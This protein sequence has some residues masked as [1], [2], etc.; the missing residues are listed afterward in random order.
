MALFKEHLY[1]M[2]AYAPPL[3]GRSVEKHLLLDFN[4]RTLP[5]S[6]EVVE[7][8]CDFI[9]SGQLQ[10]Y[11]SYGDIVSELAEYVGVSPEQLM[12]TNGSDQGIDLVVRAAVS[13]GDRAIIPAPSFAMYRQCAEVEDA[14]ILSPEYDRETGYP[15]CE[16]LAEISV[17]TRLIVVA[18]P[19]NPCGTI[20]SRDDLQMILRAAPDAVVLVD[21]CYYEYSQ[22][23]VV[24]L[25]DKYPNLV[26]ARTFSK[27][28]GLPSLRF[29][30]LVSQANNI[31]QLLKIRGPYDI[32]QLSIVAVRAA[33]AAPD[34]T[35]DYVREV[36]EESKPLLE[37][38][39]DE[40]KI[41]YWPSTANYIWAFFKQPDQLAAY[42]QEQGILVRPKMDPEGKLGLRVTLG[43]L[44]QTRRVI[45]SIEA[46]Y[47]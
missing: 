22:Q 45:E 35:K 44:E 19:N 10:K 17:D 26:V 21:E 13:K 20:V 12:I 28:W 15:T 7:A 34:Y 16:V 27:T 23:T 11:P 37:S 46:F 39:L 32:N 40:R 4:E 14:E 29:G 18:Q 38:W 8:L 5:V 6:D 25:V 9:R 3:E 1:Q 47:R 2:A 36:M 41:T 31:E 24:D 42:L 33:L 43:N 30:F